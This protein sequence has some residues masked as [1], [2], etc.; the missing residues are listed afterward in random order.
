MKP[1][2]VYDVL[3]K[4]GAT[5]LHHANTVATS[6]TFLENAALLSRGYVE[7][8]GLTQTPQGSDALD[9]QYG[10]WDGVFLDHVDIHHRGGRRKGPNQYGPVLFVLELDSLLLLPSAT[11]IRVTKTN[12]IHWTDKQEVGERWFLTA[13]QLENAIGY[14]DFDKMLVINT[15]SGSVEFPN[16]EVRIALD[17]P[18]RK[19]TGGT[20]AYQHAEQRLTAAARKGG[21]SVHI[22][23]HECQPGCICL[24][25]Y[26]GYDPRYFDRRFE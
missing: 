8:H 5:H 1:K 6:C 19:M 17:D 4:I 24:A 16:H 9:R 7:N 11:D 21:M 10:I 12:P 15:P 26:A 2:E 3:F 18:K 22:A 13:Q 23:P 25:K 20:D 14:G